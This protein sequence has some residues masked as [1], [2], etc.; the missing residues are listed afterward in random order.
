MS[1]RNLLMHRKGT[2]T[3]P[4]DKGGRGGIYGDKSPATTAKSPQAPRCK[5]GGWLW[6]LAALVALPAGAAD[7]FKD[8]PDLPP[9]KQVAAAMANSPAVLAAQGGIGLE[10]ANQA[11]LEAGPHETAVRLGGA[12]RSAND[13]NQPSARYKEWDIGLER[14]IRLPGKAALDG[15]LG[16]QGVAEARLMYG[17]ALHEAGRSVLKLWFGWMREH[18]QASQWQA[19]VDAL[20]QQLDIVNKR[21]RAGDAPRLDALLAE[22]AQAQAE[23]SLQQARLREQMAATELTRRY[24]GI[25]LPDKPVLAVPEPVKEDLGFW[26]ERI[27]QHNHELGVARAEVK[28][29]QLLT[30]RAQADKIPDPTVGLR[31]GSERDGMEKLVGLSVVIPLPGGARSAAA[32]G[33]L[34]Q[35]DIAVQREAGV[36]RKLETEIAN[37]YLAAQSAYDA[38]QK[39][40]TVAERMR[41]NASLMQRAYSLGE[42]GLNEVLTARRQSLEAGLAAV[43]AQTDAAEARYRLMLDAHLL[44]PLDADEGEAEHAHY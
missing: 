34:A 16:R 37:G 19:Q 14:P 21:V 15:E 33:A 9:L 10:Q 3:P 18:F 25:T 38:W 32:Q 17:D 13:L 41:S 5:R 31:Y 12:R 42:A 28:R 22:A 20:R 2:N 6:F 4:F 39:T 30:S 27:L 7:E 43:L 1:L 35:S 24:S 36:L 8:Y 44:W 29:W 11:R 26:H 23:A 40:D